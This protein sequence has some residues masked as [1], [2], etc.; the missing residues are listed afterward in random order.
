M[1]ENFCLFI[2]IN[3][4]PISGSVLRIRN[5][6]HP[7]R[8]FN[9]YT[10]GETVTVKCPGIGKHDALI[11]KIGGNEDKKTIE[12]VL[13]D[14]GRFQELLL[15]FKNDVLP[16]G[17]NNIVVSDKVKTVVVKP[18]TVKRKVCFSDK[19]T[20]AVEEDKLETIAEELALADLSQSVQKSDETGPLVRSSLQLLG[21]EDSAFEIRR[22]PRRTHSTPCSESCVSR[23]EFI[24]LQ[25]QCATVEFWCRQM[26]SDIQAMK[27]E[28]Q[29]SF[30]NQ[31]DFQQNFIHDN[32]ME[33]SHMSA[34]EEAQPLTS[35]CSKP[36]L[37][38][39]ST[40]T[41]P[42][43][44]TSS[45]SMTGSYAGY[46]KVQILEEAKRQKNYKK[47]TARVF[48]LLFTKQE[49]N[50]RSLF[51][52]KNTSGDVRPALADQSKLAFL[53]DCI[54]EVWGIRKEMVRVV[55]RHLLKPSRIS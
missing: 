26:W 6:V 45:I 27:A 40:P 37:S 2:W 15:K 55:L 11:G 25:S 32:L 54:V 17:G 33:D 18:K 34:S 30:Q 31:H 7:R 36:T 43:T 22:S 50:G 13:A 8:D 10:E 49:I 44:P 20:A 48:R 35:E 41:T 24:Q 39:P 42:T 46:S 53:E 12:A 51:G 9:A 21:G 5:I 1:A 52:K 23:Q 28:R 16:D 29:E 14:S 4:N 47:A 19:Q 3:D 38:T